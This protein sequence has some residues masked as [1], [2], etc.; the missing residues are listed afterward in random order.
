MTSKSILTQLEPA[1]RLE[2]VYK[3]L[4]PEPL[5]TRPEIETFYR[6]G[7]NKVRGGDKVE[8]MALGLGRSWGANF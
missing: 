3:T 5:L 6:Y 1:T 2:D 8:K 4:S 7:L